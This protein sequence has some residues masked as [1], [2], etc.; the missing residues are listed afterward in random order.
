[1]RADRGRVGEAWRRSDCVED[2][3]AGG[4]M[5][6]LGGVARALL[7]RGGQGRSTGTA[8]IVCHLGNRDAAVL[9]AQ[10]LVSCQDAGIHRANGGLALRLEIREDSSELRLLI[11]QVPVI[12]AKT[13]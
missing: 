7:Q 11:K 3:S 6:R 9:L 10:G 5:D 4:A 1:M 12:G 8:G 2:A 13:R